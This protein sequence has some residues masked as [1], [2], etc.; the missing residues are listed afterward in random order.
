MISSW[1]CSVIKLRP[2]IVT[3]G[4]DLVEFITLYFEALNWLFDSYSLD[5]SDNVEISRDVARYFSK[6]EPIP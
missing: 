5:E 4:P 6:S 3:F 1:L 2:G